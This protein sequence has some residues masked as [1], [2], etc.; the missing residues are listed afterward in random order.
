[1]NINKLISKSAN[2]FDKYIL[3][4]SFC[5]NKYTLARAKIIEK[6]YVKRR[7]YYN[8]LCE[9]KRIKYSKDNLIKDI[10][11]HLKAKG[12]SSK[13]KNIGEVHTFAFIPRVGW[14]YQLYHDLSVLGDVSEF[15]Y[16]KYGFSMNKLINAKN[17]NL[18]DRMNSKAFGKI[19]QIHKERPIDW[20]FVYASG[21]EISPKLVQK[22][23]D[24]LGIPTLKM[25]LDDKQ[26]WEGF[27]NGTHRVG[28]IDLATV[29]DISWTSSRITCEWYLAEGGRPIYLPEGSDILTY[30][31]KEK[32]DKILISFVGQKYGFRSN[33]INFLKSNGIRIST[34][35]YGWNNEAVPFYKLADIYSK[36]LINLGMGGIGFAEFITNVKGRDF[37]VPMTGGGVYITSFNPDLALHFNVGEE[38]ICYRSR[39]EMLEL[40]RYY[41]K[42]KDE[43]RNIAKA[44]RERCLREHRWLHRYIEICQILGIIDDSKSPNLIINEEST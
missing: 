15:D 3:S 22:I 10:K 44:G 21:Y 38:I 27:S 25:C 39:E 5:E 12:I 29:F 23:S 17:T 20:I 35:G 36:S 31:P 16:T 42:H 19:K 11:K 6:K 34:F 28:Q 13:K 30:F 40:I 26:S 14:H 18:L 41:L 24:E 9:E 4:I 8:K 2:L 1:M 7:E 32:T 43:A 37:D 33:V